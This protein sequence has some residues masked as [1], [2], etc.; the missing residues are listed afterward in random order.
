MDEDCSYELENSI[1][2]NASGLMDKSD[3]AFS[4]MSE[5][6]NSKKSSNNQNA[7]NDGND[8]NEVVHHDYSRE[9][10]DN[11]MIVNSRQVT[12]ESVIEIPEEMMI[13]HDDIGSDSTIQI[14]TEDI[15]VGSNTVRV[16]ENSFSMIG[17]VLIPNNNEFILCYNENEVESCDT[18]E[19][20]EA[21]PSLFTSEDIESADST[22]VVDLSHEEEKI[23][24][25]FKSKA[26][27]PRLGF[28][29]IFHQ[30]LEIFSNIFEQRT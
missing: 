18:V 28:M 25:V 3:H 14:I 29:I 5:L 11:E 30:P 15:A 10:H 26:D 4:M 21:D 12:T 8:T 7:A 27:V 16:E 6:N 13:V 9:E 19:L 24:Q 23:R 2:I 17:Q 22:R 20:I 1:E